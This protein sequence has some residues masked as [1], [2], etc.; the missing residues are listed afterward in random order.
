VV[1]AYD[2]SDGWY[3]HAFSGVT[4]PSTTV[5]DTLTGVGICGTGTPT[6]GQQGRC[7]YGPRMPL[8]VVSAWSK[9]NSVDHTLTDQSSITR[10]V[11]DNWGL[12]RIPGSLDSTAGSIEGMFDFA[13]KQGNGNAYG[14]A[15]NATPYLLDPANGKGTG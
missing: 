5:A 2:D 12:P 10:F 1:I 9:R 7:G 8:L 14:N 11:E 15:P 3:D 13:A 6:A 4:N